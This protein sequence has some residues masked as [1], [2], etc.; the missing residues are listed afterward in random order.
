MGLIL[1][2]IIH[3]H[4]RKVPW[5]RDLHTQISILVDKYFFHEAVETFSDTWIRI[6]RRTCLTP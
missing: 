1:L 6:K 2:N 3:G 4:T 5:Q